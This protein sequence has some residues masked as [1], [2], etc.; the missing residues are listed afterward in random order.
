MPPRNWS[1]KD[2]MKGSWWLINCCNI[3]WKK[4][5]IQ[6][7]VVGNGISEPSTVSNTFSNNSSLQPTG[8][9]TT[10]SPQAMLA[11]L[12]QLLKRQHDRC[13]RNLQKGCRIP[14]NGRF[15]SRQ[16]SLKLRASA[17]ENRSFS[18]KKEI[19]SSSNRQF[20]GAKWWIYLSDRIPVTTR[21]TWHFLAWKSQPKPL[22]GREIQDT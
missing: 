17:H 3:S 5:G 2:P 13:F 14:K 19:S 22:F 4:P 11:R 1:S 7:I 15:F 16:E 21:M 12:M 8:H 18:P 9:Q 6:G 10:I 20:S